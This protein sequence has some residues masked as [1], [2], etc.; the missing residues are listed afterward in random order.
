MHKTL[1]VELK[2]G[3]SMRIGGATVT[4]EEKSGQRARLRVLAGPGVPV[5]PPPRSGGSEMAKLG[6][7][8]PS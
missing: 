4:L 6:A 5:E 2:V 8:P 3:Q 1:V 7:M